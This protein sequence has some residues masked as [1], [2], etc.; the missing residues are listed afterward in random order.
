[1]D[2]MADGLTRAEKE[3]VIRD[4]IRAMRSQKHEWTIEEKAVA[5][6]HNSDLDFDDDPTFDEI[7]R[8]MTGYKRRC[9]MPKQLKDDFIKDVNDF[10]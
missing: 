2:A 8:I 6:A 10:F 1:M 7:C 3:T 5:Y 4:H 9:Q